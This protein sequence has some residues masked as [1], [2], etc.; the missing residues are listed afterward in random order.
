MRLYKICWSRFS[1]AYTLG[2]SSGTL[3]DQLQL[4]PFNQG[5]IVPQNDIGQY[6]EIEGF[7][8]QFYIEILDLGEVQDIVYEAVEALARSH[9][10]V[11]VF[12][13]FI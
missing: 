3:F 7:P 10:Q 5:L 11:E 6:P 12:D 4:F 8:H 13:L 9:N 1:S 2:R